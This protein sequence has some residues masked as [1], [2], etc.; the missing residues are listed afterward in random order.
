MAEQ[1]IIRSAAQS[2][3][4]LSYNDTPIHHIPSDPLDPPSSP[5]PP[6]NTLKFAPRI[7]TAA[8]I[9]MSRW[10]L[11]VGRNWAAVHVRS[12]AAYTGNLSN[13]VRVEEVLH[14]I[15]KTHQTSGACRAS[16]LDAIILSITTQQDKVSWKRALE[17]E[18]KIPVHVFNFS[19]AH[20]DLVP[21]SA[22]SEEGNY[23][24]IMQDLI[25]MQIWRDAPVFIGCRSTMDEFMF[26]LRSNDERKRSCSVTSQPCFCQHDYTAKHQTDCF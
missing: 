5:R 7:Q 3:A 13:I 16:P 14:A 8:H 21:N 9:L 12:G 17:R 26:L 15:Y 2:F 19:G 11:E 18:L 23:H 25:E 20:A 1:S 24:T 6:S 10:N 4:V 22:S